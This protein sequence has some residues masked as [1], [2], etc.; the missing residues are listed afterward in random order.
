[1]EIKDK[2]TDSQKPLRRVP[3]KKSN[4]KPPKFNLM[5]LYAILIIGL[6]VIPTIWGG[7]TGKQIDFQTF[8]NTMLKAHDVD[9][10]TAYKEGDL[11][12]ADVYIKKD[13]LSKP[14][15]ADVNKQQRS[16]AMSNDGPQYYF[17]DASYESLKQSLT[18]AEKDLPDAEKTP[19]KY[20]Q[21]KENL[22]SN[23]LVQCIIMAVLLVGVWL[24]IM[25][26]M[27][28]GAGGGPGGQIFNIGKSKAT[29][30][31]KEAQVT[32]TFN[33]VA[34]LEEAKQEVM[35]IV[36]FLKNPKK[37][38]NLG[39]KI[40]KGALLVGSPGTGKTLLAKAVAGEAHVPFFSLSGSD[41]VE[42]FVGVGASR[43]RDLFKQAKDKAP[44][45]IFIDEIDAIGRARGKNNIV[46][47]ND[48]RENTLNQ[49]LVEMDG[50]GTDSGIIILAATNRP[51]VLDS[52]LL[53][54]GQISID[55]P[56]LNG[57]EQIFKVHLKPL[58]LAADVDAKKLSAQT[59]GFAGAEIANVCNEAALIAARQNKE[60]VDMQDFQDAIDRVIGGLEKKNTLISPEEKRVVAYHEAGHAIAGWFLEHTDPLVKVS[61]VPRGVAALG[62]AQYL[63]NER[64]LVAKEELMD[65]MILSM[66][67]RV[68]E[69]IVFG[70]I[71]TGALS[72][73]ERITRLA[74][75]MVK[76]Y[77]MNEKVGNLSFYD[78][79]GENQFN[80]PYSDTT[81]ELIDSEVRKLVDVIYSKTKDLLT[82]HRE[83]LEKV[84]A[85]LLEKEVL[86]QADLEELLGKR[87]FEHRTAYD[88]F[89]NGDNTLTPD[90][91]AIPESVINP[92]A[93]NMETPEGK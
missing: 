60:A 64:F 8:S 33:D 50:F 43:V 92:E 23:W 38:T 52:A 73:L 80:K 91:N 70:K 24:F 66:G 65:D 55:K 54:P 45:I 1:M 74:Y 86:F 85:K 69:D 41:F 14:K 36:D 25:R 88:K 67:G 63:P 26:R 27:S 39:G 37:Y 20:E 90:N 84:A 56:D 48:E 15:Y 16:F 7:S 71:T 34:G 78:P 89:V 42:M 61:I 31:D 28:G 47:G 59:P 22:L 51:D 4:P 18:A 21:G 87:P 81:A 93:S 10:I 2:K 5:W 83:G 17:T 79:H 44:C 13:S 11:V 3:N 72:D 77:G 76:I 53:Q 82:Q 58:K 35:E 46:G 32:V 75:G 6:F 68:A 49:L 40:P 9:H 62:Y 19:I 57:R 30:F 29:L 12:K